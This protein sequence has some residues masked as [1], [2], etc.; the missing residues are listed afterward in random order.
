[1][2]YVYVRLSVYLL[3]L[4]CGGTSYGIAAV[5]ESHCDYVTRRTTT[6][7]GTSLATDSVGPSH[8]LSF[9]RIKNSLSRSTGVTALSSRAT[10]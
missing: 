10:E 4:I 5:L 6:V 7:F 8:L 3:S 1:M 2:Y 9:L